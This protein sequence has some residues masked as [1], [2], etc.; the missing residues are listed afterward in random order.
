[1]LALQ[2]HVRGGCRRALPTRGRV[3]LQVTNHNLRPEETGLNTVVWV[4]ARRTCSHAP[5]IKV[6]K[7]IGDVMQSDGEFLHC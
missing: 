3:H 2:A 5:R 1:M 6:S 4:E 7:K